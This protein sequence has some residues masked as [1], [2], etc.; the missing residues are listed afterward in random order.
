MLYSKN[1]ETLETYTL[2]DDIRYYENLKYLPLNPYPASI[3]SAMIVY[4]FRG[5]AQ[6]HV[7]DSMHWIAPKELIILF[8]GQFISFSEVSDDFLTITLVVSLPLHSDA[9]SGVP[10]FSPHFFFY[11]RSHFVY[12]QTETG[13]QRLFNFFGLMKEKIKS[14]DLYRRELVIHLL[15]Y[16][17]LELYNNFQKQ[18]ILSLGNKQET[19][20]EELT[21]KFFALIMEHFRENKDVAFYAD[22]L[23]ISSKY[24]SMVIKE[25]SGKSAKDWIIEY[26]ILEIKALLKNTNLNIQGIALKTNFANQSSLGRFFRKHTG[27]SLSQY[28]TNGLDICV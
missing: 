24:L 17:Y 18:T 10:L 8:P 27:M 12:R 5:K 13:I 22:K 9:L 15:R 3:Q 26:I 1:R 21:N 16:L 14:R 25:I 11:M 7:Y 20:K 6:L 28:R 2:G 23:C 4:C 19:R